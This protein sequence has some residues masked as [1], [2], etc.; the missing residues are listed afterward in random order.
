MIK[1]VTTDEKGLI[2]LDKILPG[3]YYIKEVKA[4]EGF[5]KNEEILEVDVNL[6]EKIEIT[7]T[8][9]KIVIEPVQEIQ[10]EVKKLPVTG[11]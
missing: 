2:I 8:N 11:M 7:I 1:T 5:E 3:K 6:N 4:P 9:S 10:E